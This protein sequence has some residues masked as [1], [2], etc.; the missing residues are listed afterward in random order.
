MY[1]TV[2]NRVS[3][4]LSRLEC[5]GAIAAHR[6]LH[7][8]GSGSSLASASR[9]AGIIG[10]HHAQPIFVFLVEMGVSPRW[11]G[12]SRTPDLKLEC[13]GVLIAHCSLNLLGASN[14][15]SSA[16]QIHTRLGNLQRKRFNWTYRFTWLK[17]PHNH[18]SRQGGATSSHTKVLNLGRPGDSRQRS[19]T[20]RQRDSFGRRGCFAGAP[21]W[22]FPVRSI[23]TDGLGWSH[24]HKESSNWK[25]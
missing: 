5:S 16:S 14:F 10:T 24:P 2:S 13:S 1:Q 23:W 8:L 9:V 7:L 25:R 22:R 19:H 17:K 15:P 12:W 18:G 3:L 11:P 20:S 6:Y 4:C 21:A